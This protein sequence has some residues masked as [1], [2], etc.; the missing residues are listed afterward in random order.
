MIDHPP[1][2]NCSIFD[3]STH[4]SSLLS[5][6][7]LALAL[8][9]VPRPRLRAGRWRRGNKCGVDVGVEMVTEWNMAAFAV[10]VAQQRKQV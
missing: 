5:I 1:S 10:V 2:I 8:V 9:L 6:W 3:L 4:L 7:R